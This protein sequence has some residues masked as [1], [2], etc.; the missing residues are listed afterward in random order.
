[1]GLFT[2]AMVF[3]RE[4]NQTLGQAD[5]ADAQRTLID[6]ALDLVVGAQFVGTIPE[7]R[8]QQ[9]ELLSHSCLLILIAGIQLASGDF[10]HII[11]FGKETVNAFLLVLDVHAFDGQTHNI[12]GRE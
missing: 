3:S 12:D 5:E 6:N 10:Q 4:G 11:E 9:G 7:L 2:L 1:M 8:H